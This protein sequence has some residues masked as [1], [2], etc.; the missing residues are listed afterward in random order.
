MLTMD[1]RDHPHPHVMIFITFPFFTDRGNAFAVW[2]AVVGPSEDPLVHFTR[3]HNFPSE[4]I[5]SLRRM[6]KNLE[7]HGKCHLKGSDN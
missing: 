6:M 2:E 5:P 3:G 7:P 4:P 1:F